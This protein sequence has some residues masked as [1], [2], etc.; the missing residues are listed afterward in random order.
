MYYT[1]GS[2]STTIP[3]TKVVVQQKHQELGNAVVNCTSPIQSCV[4]KP[5]PLGQKHARLSA[6]MQWG[7]TSANLRV[8]ILVGENFANHFTGQVKY[9]QMAIDL[10]IFSL[11]HNCAIYLKYNLY[12]I[13]LTSNYV[14]MYVKHCHRLQINALIHIIRTNA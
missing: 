14:H 1:S 2:N 12:Q 5:F 11:P 7:K 8:S 10:P 3:T 9:W 6:I 4:P 13:Q